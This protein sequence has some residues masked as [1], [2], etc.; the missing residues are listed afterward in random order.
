MDEFELLKRQLLQRHETDLNRVKQQRAKTLSEITLVRNRAN[1]MLS[2][3]M[4]S[5][6][7]VEAV[8]ERLLHGDIDAPADND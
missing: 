6:I 2:S 5:M 8:N 4:H 7:D 1:L 3:F